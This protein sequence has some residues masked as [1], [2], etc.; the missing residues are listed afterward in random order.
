MGPPHDHEVAG[1]T[2]RFAGDG[3]LVRAKKN[4]ARLKDWPMI[5]RPGGEGY[6]EPLRRHVPELVRFWLRGVAH[7][8]VVGGNGKGAPRVGARRGR[9]A[10]A[11]QAA[12]SARLEDV[13]ECAGG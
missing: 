7:A 5:R 12:L 8:G 4:P 1:F 9:V 6:Y 2:D 11:V 3:R 10:P 13:S